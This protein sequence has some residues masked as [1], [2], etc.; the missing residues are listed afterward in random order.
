M[1]SLISCRVLDVLCT[2]LVAALSLDNIKATVCASFA[3][4]ATFCLLLLFHQTCNHL[5]PQN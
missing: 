1:H 4:L 5:V 3:L 2:L